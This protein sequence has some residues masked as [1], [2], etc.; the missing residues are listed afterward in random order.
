MT[1][2]HDQQTDGLGATGKS[3]V[4]RACQWPPTGVDS[5]GYSEIHDDVF[6]GPGEGEASGASLRD[7]ITGPCSTFVLAYDFAD[8]GSRENVPTLR[9]ARGLVTSMQNLGQPWTPPVDDHMGWQFYPTR[10]EVDVI[11]NTHY[12]LANASCG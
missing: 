1:Q 8:M 7:R 4:F 12:T 5:D 3:I 10:D 9:A 6:D 11:K 2:A